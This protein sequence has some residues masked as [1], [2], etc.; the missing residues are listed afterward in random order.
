MSHSPTCTALYAVA[1]CDCGAP[2]QHT[3]PEHK[4]P[5]PTLI[6]DWLNDLRLIMAIFHD[7]DP[8]DD[9]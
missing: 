7:H 9:D 6:R 8:N 3:M 4:P 2:L 5:P 1:P